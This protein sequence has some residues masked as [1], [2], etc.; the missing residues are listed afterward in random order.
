MSCLTEV[1]HPRD[2]ICAWA[3]KTDIEH[4]YHDHEWG[5]PVDDER[6]LF[7]FVVLE[8]AQAGLS[9]LTILKR[10][11]GYRRV[12]H[13]FDV[14]RVAAMSEAEQAQALTDAGII[15]NR[16]K[17]RSAVNNAAVF[18]RIQEEFGSFAR[19]IWGFVNGQPIQNRWQAMS[20]IPARTE[21]SDAIAKDLKQRGFSF[22]GST[23]VYAHMQATGMVNDHVVDCP[24]HGEVA[25]LKPQL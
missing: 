23:I 9:W 16:A 3:R 22:M 24:R 18:L 20:E 10:R 15:R 1:R 21:L 8:G 12:F 14:A 17:V 13:D 7:E 5:V 19:Y 2:A 4:R 6:K 11:D 25:G